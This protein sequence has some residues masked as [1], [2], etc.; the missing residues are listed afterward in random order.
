MRDDGKEEMRKAHGWKTL[1]R[2]KEGERACAREGS[3]HC[4][5][6]RKRDKKKDRE[7][8]GDSVRKLF[9]RANHRLLVF[10]TL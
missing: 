8:A 9:R 3:Q 2:E 5:C 1:F 6:H 4:E 7:R 10:T